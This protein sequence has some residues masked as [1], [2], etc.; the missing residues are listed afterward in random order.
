MEA[1]ALFK[2]LTTEKGK[3]ARRIDEINEEL[4]RIHREVWES[5]GW[6]TEAVLVDKNGKEGKIIELYF[7][8]Y[9]L[10]S[11]PQVVVV[12]RVKSGEWGKA[13]RRAYRGD[14]WR[15]QNEKT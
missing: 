5:K 6:N 3:L 11:P 13:R 8:N 4:Y 7:N 2:K 10:S 9:D 12:E 15:L 14:G 1:Q